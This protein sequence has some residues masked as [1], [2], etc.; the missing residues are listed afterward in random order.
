MT[1]TRCSYRGDREQTLMAYLYD[2]ITPIE[3]STFESHLAGCARCSEELDELRGVRAARVSKTQ[4]P[5]LA[6]PNR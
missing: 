4:I 5:A 2:D 1:D 3:R 6:A